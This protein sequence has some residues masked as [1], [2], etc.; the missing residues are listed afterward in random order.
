MKTLIAIVHCRTRQPYMD[1]IRSTWLLCVPEGKADVRFFVGRGEHIDFPQDVVELDCD[2]SYIGLPEKV[3]AIAT[4]ALANGYDYI[5]KCDDDV[6]L[7][8][9]KLLN[10]GY[11]H[12]DFSGHRNSSKEDPA[13]PYGFCYWLSKRSMHIVSQAAL[14][15][16]GY[17]E[18]WV[19]TNLYKQGILLHHDPRY[20]LYFGKKE[21]YVSK[22]RPLRFIRENTLPNI[23]PVEGNFAWCLYIPWL[24]YKN[25]PV[26]RN[27]QEFHK[28]WNE[29]KTQDC[30]SGT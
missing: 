19:R 9:N 27:I 30:P 2:D 5:L 24:G 21:E 1:A 18:G 22:R 26:E 3:R 11:E 28:I 6:V 8:P 13:P 17:D 25:L 29:V 12:Y 23:K 7:L 20:F 4:W 16:D 10:S 15:A 14:P